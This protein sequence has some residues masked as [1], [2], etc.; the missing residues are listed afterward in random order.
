[1]AKEKRDYVVVDADG[2]FVIA[3][4]DVEV[5]F[6]V[7]GVTVGLGWSVGAAPFKVYARLDGGEAY[8]L[9][10]EVAGGEPRYFE[11]TGLAPDL[12]SRP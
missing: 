10:G 5:D 3:R 6:A 12:S 9:I 8:G 1:M 4:T 7:V 11:D 2:R